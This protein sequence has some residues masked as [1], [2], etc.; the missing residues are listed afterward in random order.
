MV[1]SIGIARGSDLGSPLVVCRSANLNRWLGHGVSY[2]IPAVTVEVINFVNRSGAGPDLKRPK[3]LGVGSC[4]PRPCTGPRA[5]AVSAWTSAPTVRH[6]A[7]V[8]LGP[9]AALPRSYWDVPYVGARHPGAV[10]RGEVDKGANCQLWAYEVLA[11]FG[12]HLPD[13][14]SDE[15]WSDDASTEQVS[16][17]R[18]LDLLLYN[19]T[20]DSFGAHVGLWT[21]TAVAHLCE[22]VG[23]PVVWPQAEFDARPRYAVRIG[24]KRPR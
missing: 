21:G 2:R 23:V 3:P 16:E 8:E 6:D 24:F 19:G 11:H 14:R 15:L 20:D 7:V 18:P 5:G 10:P 22:E 12:L 4:G 17:P 9:L 1:T 13:L